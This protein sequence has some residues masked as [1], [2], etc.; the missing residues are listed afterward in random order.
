[1]SRQSRSAGRIA[2]VRRVTACAAVFAV[3]TLFALAPAPR[4]RAQRL[5]VWQD[6]Q[7]EFAHPPGWYRSEAAWVAE[8]ILIVTPSPLSVDPGELFAPVGLDVNAAIHVK[9]DALDP[10]LRELPLD[11]IAAA[12][13]EQVSEQLTGEGLEFQVLGLGQTTIDGHEA[14]IVTTRQD[15]M[16]SHAL[17]VRSEEYLYE[18]AL[19]YDAAEADNYQTLVQPI[20]ASVK[21]KDGASASVLTEERTTLLARLRVPRQ[22]HERTSEGAVPQVV[23]SREALSGAGARYQAG[24]S[25]LKITGYRR[26]L[27]LSPQMSQEEVYDAWLRAYLEG[28][29]GSSYRLVNAGLVEHAA[30]PSLLIELSFHDRASRRYV[31][32]FNLVTALQD[33]LYIAVYEAPVEEFYRLRATY[34]DSIA[35]IVWR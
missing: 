14:V 30:G 35:S 24:I 32:L 34:L 27:N 13:V 26:A 33:D 29:S 19:T 12:L 18:V 1:M 25:L 3:L 28:L 23:I 17:L 20:L 10:L 7:V 5:Q 4:V 9:I 6:P 15:T 2:R 8:R 31:Q 22:W 11:E 21:L 16:I